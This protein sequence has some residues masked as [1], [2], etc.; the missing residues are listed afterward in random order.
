MKKLLRSGFFLLTIIFL[1]S[2]N[3]NEPVTDIGTIQK[4]LQTV[5]KDNAITKCAVFSSQYTEYVNCDFLI[6]NGT[7]IITRN[8]YGI[9]TKHSFNLLYLSS[10]K[11]SG[12]YINFYFLN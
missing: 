9:I 6:S 5:V 7:L 12:N 2:C 1:V 3:N 4:E 10:Y 11:Y 8:E